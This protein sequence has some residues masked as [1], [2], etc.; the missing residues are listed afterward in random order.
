MWISSPDILGRVKKFVDEYATHAK[1]RG[2]LIDPLINQVCY[3]LCTNKPHEA[4][5]LMGFAKSAWTAYSDFTEA[6]AQGKVRAPRAGL[7]TFQELLTED[8]RQ[9]L[10]GRTSFPPYFLPK[11]RFILKIPQDKAVEEKFHFDETIVPTVPP[12]SPPP[13]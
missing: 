2:E 7:Q 1:I 12:S 8:I 13:K 4:R 6:N 9:I 11:L 3:Y 10:L 5:R